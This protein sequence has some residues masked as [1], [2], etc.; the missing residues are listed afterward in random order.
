MQPIIWQATRW[1]AI[2]YCTLKEQGH[3][4]V[5]TGRITG[6]SDQEP[7]A[8]LYEVEITND[9]RVSSFHIRKE[10][11]T[12][13]ELKLTSDLHGHW[14][15]KDGNH[16]GAFDDCI[17]ID[18]SLS[19]FTNTLPVK[20]L[21]FDTGEKKILNMLYIKLPEFEL[22]KVQ[23]HYTKLDNHTY[24]YENVTTDFKADIPFDEQGIVLDYPGI[25]TRIHY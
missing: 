14:F 25:F 3:H 17:D 12:T 7:F 8:I 10:G 16:I 4:H 18:I 1:P 19:P 20:R 24:R 21:H 22:Q 23:Q 15:D 2:E 5:A 6:V 11:L 9:W 13:G